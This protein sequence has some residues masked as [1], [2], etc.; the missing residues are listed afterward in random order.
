M[1][2]TPPLATPGLAHPGFC[3]QGNPWRA[4]GAAWTAVPAR[5]A[6]LSPSRRFIM[7]ITTTLFAATLL[8]VLAMAKP[9]AFETLQSTIIG[10]NDAEVQAVWDGVLPARMQTLNARFNTTSGVF[11][12]S[13]KKDRCVNTG[14]VKGSFACPARLAIITSEKTDVVQE[15]ENF[16]FS[17]DLPTSN[18]AATYIAQTRRNNTRIAVDAEEGVLMI[19]DTNNGETSSDTLT[20]KKP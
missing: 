19:E 10:K 11:L 4:H 16:T 17:G 5:A 12:F 13:I 3:H 14:N 9:T 6:A 15:F 20:F 18:T 2:M 8:P 7:S 1:T